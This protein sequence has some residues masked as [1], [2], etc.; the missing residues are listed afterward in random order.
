M[1]GKFNDFLKWFRVQQLIQCISIARQS[2]IYDCLFILKYIES[3][4][5]NQ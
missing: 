1:I 2:C 3:L 4:K 5:I